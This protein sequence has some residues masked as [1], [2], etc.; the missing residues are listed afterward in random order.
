M[1]GSSSA[2]K[3]APVARSMAPDDEN[4]MYALPRCSASL[5]YTDSL[6]KPALSPPVLCGRPGEEAMSQRSHSMQVGRHEHWRNNDEAICR[7]EQ[8]TGK[9]VEFTAVGGI[10]RICEGHCI[11]LAQDAVALLPPF[12]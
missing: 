6:K 12:P 7:A 2:S 9:G 11:V 8:H 1:R 3:R 4:P 5:P 10:V